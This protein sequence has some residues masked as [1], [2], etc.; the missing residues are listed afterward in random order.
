MNGGQLILLIT[1]HTDPILPDM[2]LTVCQ[3]GRVCK[4]VVTVRQ[5]KRSLE[6]PDV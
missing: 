3:G 4:Q 6:E 2:G 1:G 5:L